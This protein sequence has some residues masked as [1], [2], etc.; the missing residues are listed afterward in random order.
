MTKTS[1]ADAPRNSKEDTTRTQN[2]QSTTPTAA[3]Q[4]VKD[5]DRPGAKPQGSLSDQVATMESEGQAQPQ[6]DEVP[7]EEEPKGIPPLPEP[8]V[9]GVG[10]ESGPSAAK[11]GLKGEPLTPTQ[12]KPMKDATG[13]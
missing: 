7:S 10:N 4:N 13:L 1:R 2:G 12:A 11:T 3:G 9:E 6:A 5:A 8:D